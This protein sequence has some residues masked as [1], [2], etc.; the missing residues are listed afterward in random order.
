MQECRFNHR[1]NLPCVEGRVLLRDAGDEFDRTIRDRC[2]GI[3]RAATVPGRA[4]VS[5]TIRRE[6][7]L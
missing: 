4:K 5:L 7:F 6:K 3:H 2:R 1:R